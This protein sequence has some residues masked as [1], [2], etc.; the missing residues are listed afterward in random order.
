MCEVTRDFQN[1][2]SV[3]PLGNMQQEEM[4]KEEM[5]LV[6]NALIWYASYSNCNC[7]IIHIHYS[8]KSAF[9]PNKEESAAF[10]HEVIDAFRTQIPFCLCA[11]GRNEPA[12]YLYALYVSFNVT[13]V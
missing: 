5:Y 4:P 12:M 2:H 9:S 11:T 6:P 8:V 10:I 1:A 7:H 13:I 3:L